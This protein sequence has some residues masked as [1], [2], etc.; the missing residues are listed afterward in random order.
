MAKYI[1]SATKT[2]RFHH[3]DI[4]NENVSWKNK[5]VTFEKKN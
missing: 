3:I 2:L 5:N 4:S 1:F